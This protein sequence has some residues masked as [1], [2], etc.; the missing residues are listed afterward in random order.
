MNTLR[1]R[2]NDGLTGKQRRRAV[3]R[4]NRAAHRKQV[5][6]YVEYTSGRTRK[7]PLTGKLPVKYPALLRH[8]TTNPLVKSARI[9]PV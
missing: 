8:H 7:F 1:T 3:H 4:A 5:L 9:L 2:G 6:I